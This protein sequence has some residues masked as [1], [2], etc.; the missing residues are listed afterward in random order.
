MRFLKLLWIFS[1]CNSQRQVKTKFKTYTI[2][3]K[4]IKTWTND[5]NVFQ[6]QYYNQ[7]E[8][9]KFQENRL[10]YL[11]LLLVLIHWNF[12]SSEHK[13][14]LA[15][16]FPFLLLLF[17]HLKFCTEFQY[18]LHLSVLKQAWQINTSYLIPV[19]FHWNVKH[20]RDGDDEMM[21]VAVIAAAAA[22]MT[23]KVVMSA[24]KL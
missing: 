19:C 1:S 13:N 14:G 4:H 7:V 15:W 22:K 9:N 10:N 12:I 3:G 24:A 2:K 5:G 21:M 23:E 6:N 17:S 11:R 18:T 16:S 8:W 20:L